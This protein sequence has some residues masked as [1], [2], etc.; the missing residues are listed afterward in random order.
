[1]DAIVKADVELLLVNLREETFVDTLILNFE[2]T[3]HFWLIDILI[4]WSLDKDE[5][6]IYWQN[7]DKRVVVK[8]IRLHQAIAR[9]LYEQPDK[10]QAMF[11]QAVY[12]HHLRTFYEQNADYQELREYQKKTGYRG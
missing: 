12:E 6:G 9:D 11:W 8:T 5:V 10:D 4:G 2:E 1:M 7:R 3:P